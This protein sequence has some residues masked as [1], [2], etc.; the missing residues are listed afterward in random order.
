MPAVNEVMW[1]SLATDGACSVIPLGHPNGYNL[2]RKATRRKNKTTGEWEHVPFLYDEPPKQL[3]PSQVFGALEKLFF[4]E[5]TKV[6]HNAPFDQLSVAK[7]FGG[8]SR[9]RPTGTRSSPRGC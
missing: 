4:S 9:P 3:R 6:A 8:N 2:L 7:Y 1:L 5:R